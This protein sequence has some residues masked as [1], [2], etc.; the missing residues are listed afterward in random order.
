M[1]Y[2][3]EHNV[4][5]RKLIAWADRSLAHPNLK[6]VA[7]RTGSAAWQNGYLYG[8]RE[9]AKEI[10]GIDEEGENSDDGKP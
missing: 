1:T 4:D 3:N 10:L 5:L 9:L 2:T 8:R 7:T 6:Y